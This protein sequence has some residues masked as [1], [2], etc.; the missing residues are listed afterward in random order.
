MNRKLLAFFSGFPDYRFHEDIGNRLRE[1]LTC[2][3]SLV[4][5]SACCDDHARNPEDSAG[6]HGMFAEYGMPFESF[7]AI[8]AW[9][10]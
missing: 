6:M 10:R 3:E 9:M 2:R 1:E 7:C 5:I 4:F 8:R